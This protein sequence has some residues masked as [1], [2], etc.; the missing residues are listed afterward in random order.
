MHALSVIAF[1]FLDAEKAVHDDCY[2][3]V[4]PRLVP[5]G[6]LAANNA[7]NHRETLQ[8]A[9]DRALADPLVDALVVRIRKGVQ[10]CRKL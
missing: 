6:M 5:G 1:C 2:H 9:I 7:I 8:P 3:L 10:V 4:A